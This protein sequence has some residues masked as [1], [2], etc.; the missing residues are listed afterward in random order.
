[1]EYLLTEIYSDP[2]YSVKTL[3]NYQLNY[4]Y[5]Y[6]KYE[7]YSN[8]QISSKECLNDK[9]EAIRIYKSIKQELKQRVHLGFHYQHLN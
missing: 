9:R 8:A 5:D 6:F 1:M 2:L 7:S 3:T 4:F